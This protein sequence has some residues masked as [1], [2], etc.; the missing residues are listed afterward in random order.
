MSDNIYKLLKKIAWILIIL[1]VLLS[2]FLTYKVTKQIFFGKVLPFPI[3]LI[4]SPEGNKL[5]KISISDSLQ[6]YS[7]LNGKYLVQIDTLKIPLLKNYS[8]ELQ[9]FK[10]K[11]ANFVADKDSI[12][13]YF[14]DI[15][16]NIVKQQTVRTVKSDFL[17][18][19]NMQLIFTYIWI[20]FLASSLFISYLLLRY[21]QSRENILMVFF[22]FLLPSSLIP[23]PLVIMTK[24]FQY[25]HFFTFPYLGILF[26]HFVIQKISFHTKLR[27]LYLIS[28]FVSLVTFFLKKTHII[29]VSMLI[30][31]FWVIFWI[32][33][34]I[35]NL[36][37]DIKINKTIEN[38]RLFSSFI[39]VIIFIFSL[40]VLHVCGLYWFNNSNIL[41]L[42]N[43][44]FSEHILFYIATICLGISFLSIVISMF[45]FISSFTW[46]L[47]TGSI[48]EVKIRSTIIYTIVGA[49]I[50][51]IF[52]LID[53]TLG[54]FI[55]LF[56]GKF[57]GSEFIAG[58]PAS[59]TLIAVVNPIRNKVERFVD[60]KLNTSEL[61]FLEKT[62]KFADN[63][64]E[65]GVAEGFEEYICENL[66]CNL[67]IE[68]VALISF[69]NE[70]NDYK[71]N[72][73][74]GSNVIENSI[75]E[76]RENIL[77]GKTII[78]R[79]NKLSDN[80]QDISSFPFIIQILFDSKQKWYLAL[81]KKNDGSVY[82][83]N[84]MNAFTKL[85][86]KIKL[87]LK[88]ILAYKDIVN[89]KYRKIIQHQ[90]KLINDLK[91]S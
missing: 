26:Y 17:T 23:T 46:S 39:S 18:E 68:K 27:K 76:D 72:E 42:G 50:I 69:D 24:Y 22:F 54:V 61:S 84:D 34:G 71:F 14:K 67:P 52:G 28:F 53:Y 47:L 7:N 80:P 73:V 51:S 88:F 36:R 20:L 77:K 16:D 65:E 81:G 12:S 87:P 82:N 62:E 11:F 29:P 55:Q 31:Y 91:E 30:P 9:V 41:E 75:V 74:R 63:L 79:Y 83:K 25:F 45:W 60:N 59:I 19:S 38:K 85:A 33:K 89:N 86:D 2:T 40:I 49:I 66:I 32:L 13:I 1:L 35:Y 48:L 3:E 90:Q 8:I 21:S 64:S 43:P 5:W 4:T 57:I 6:G 44:I 10:Q 70:L 58:I 15:S 37:N 78:Q 56:F